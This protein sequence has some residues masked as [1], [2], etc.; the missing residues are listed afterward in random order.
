[1]QASSLAIYPTA[2][3]GENMLD[4]ILS[5]VAPGLRK[6]ASVCVV[7]EREG[8]PAFRW[9]HTPGEGSARNFWPASAIKLPAAVAAVERVNALGFGLDTVV[10]F[11]HQEEG[12]HWVHDTARGLREMTSEVFRRSSNEDFTLLLRLAGIDWVNT[13]FLVP[14]KGFPHTA[15]M[16]GYVAGETRPWSYVRPEPQRIT[17]LEADGEKKRVFAHT[18]SG[19][20]YAE[21]RGATII[22][23]KTGNVSSTAELVECLRRLIF[24]DQ[25]PE[26]ERYAI[27]SGQAA[28]LV[29]GGGGF[30]GLETRNADSGP[31]AWTKAAELVFPTARFYHK[32]GLISNYAMDLAFIDDSADTGKRFFLM[33]VIAAGSET[34][35]AGGEAL[36]SEMARLICEAV[37]AGRL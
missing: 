28:F 4:E 31:T 11:E 33:P 18:W 27:T 19:R 3:A 13:Q 25:L 14:K 36:V 17:L 22:D 6:W 37:K 21:E 34:T 7:D 1:M 15:I 24:H 26:S 23:A 10:S 30:S 20:S 32:S 29:H 9:H 35:P 2:R 5:P 16:R 8:A 12:G